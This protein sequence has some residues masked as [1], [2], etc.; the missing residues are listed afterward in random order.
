MI[1]GPAEKKKVVLVVVDI[2][3][4]VVVKDEM[5]RVE[6]ERERG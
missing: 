3:V 1:F 2:A 5:V 6:K 4:D